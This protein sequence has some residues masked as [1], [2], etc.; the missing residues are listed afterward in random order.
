MNDGNSLE[1]IDYESDDM[2][3]NRYMEGHDARLIKLYGDTFLV[4]Y[5]LSFQSSNI[6]LK[7][8]NCE[9][10][11]ILIMTR[12]ININ[13]NGKLE[14]GERNIFCPEISNLVE[15]NWSFFK[16]KDNYFFSYGLTPKHVIYNM[17]LSL[18]AAFCEIE[19]KEDK[20]GY[21]GNYEK[22]NKV[23]ISVSTPSIQ[24]MENKERY[25]AVGH[26]KYENKEEVRQIEGP[27]K[28]FLKNKEKNYKRHYNYDYL[29]FIYEFD[30][31]NGEI[32]RISDMFI[33][34]NSE[35]LLVFPTGLIY[36]EDEL[37][38]L[39]GDHDSKCKAMIIKQNIV[40]KLLK[41]PRDENSLHLDEINDFIFPTKCYKKSDMCIL[42]NLF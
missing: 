16:Y 13:K 26:V 24:S 35:Y 34:E 4:S 11:C 19:Y 32:T 22:E 33:P 39:Y 40:T 1:Y 31:E 38:I 21:Y 20:N 8:A 23:K 5:N 25:I 17:M 36:I 7:E 18:D 2:E 15:K 3:D 12:T 10:G 41:N 9:K 30:P 27:L 6:E 37:W 29:M 14:L 42:L 28:D